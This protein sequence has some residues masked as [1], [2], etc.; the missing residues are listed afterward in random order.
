M[1]INWITIHVEDLAESK[2]FYGE[3]LGLKLQ[4]E[5]SP[6]ETRTLAFFAADNGM[7]V[8]LVYNEGEK[9]E[10]IPAG[11]VSIGLTV[12]NY[13]E[14]LKRSE[15]KGIITAGPLVL[16]GNMHCFFI[17]DPMGTGI[18]IIRGCK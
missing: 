3:F 14:L 8:E 18:Q 16:G 5:F 9:C 6:T 1:I 11:S 7:Q 10:K 17:S 2:A 12:E 13:D 15:E 4:N